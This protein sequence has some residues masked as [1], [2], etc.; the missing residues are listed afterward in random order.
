MISLAYKIDV[1]SS[2]PR[3]IPQPSLLT[4]LPVDDVLEGMT[5]VREHTPEGLELLLDYFDNSYVSGAF[6]RIQPS[7]LPN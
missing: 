1:Q 4:F 6:R 5:Y 2:V 7:Q 3:L